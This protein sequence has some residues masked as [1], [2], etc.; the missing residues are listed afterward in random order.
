MKN[1]NKIGENQKEKSRW[2]AVL[3]CA[4]FRVQGRC[5]KKET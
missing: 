2:W 4:V 5:S 3:L 1:A